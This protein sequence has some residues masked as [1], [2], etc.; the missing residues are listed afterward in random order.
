MSTTRDWEH[1]IY[2]DVPRIAIPWNPPDEDILNAIPQTEYGPG[3]CTFLGIPG[4]HRGVFVYASTPYCHLYG[5]AQRSGSDVSNY[6]QMAAALC[7][8]L[9]PPKKTK[10]TSGYPFDHERYYWIVGEVVIRLYITD[11]FKNNRDRLE[12][13]FIRPHPDWMSPEKHLEKYS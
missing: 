1:Y 7:S 2:L 10:M 3:P 11:C 5:E 8:E 12:V 4:I 13:M 6:N 9:G